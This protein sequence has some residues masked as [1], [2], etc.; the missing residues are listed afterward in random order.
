MI[1]LGIIIAVLVGVSQVIKGL[2]LKA[3]FIPVVNLVLGIG[4]GF[5][6][7]DMSVAEQIVTGAIIGLSA[8]GLYDQKKIVTKK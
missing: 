7:K 1:E 6:L 8:S 5:L 4:A 3:K 2:G